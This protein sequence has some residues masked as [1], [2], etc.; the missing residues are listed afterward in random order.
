MIISALLLLATATALGYLKFRTPE[1]GLR[2]TVFRN[3]TFTG[4]P[5]AA[6]ADRKLSV[7]EVATA[8]GLPAAAPFGI[9]W[10][11]WVLIEQ[12]GSYE[13]RLTVDDG[14]VAWIG[15]RTIADVMG[16]PGVYERRGT[17]ML[18]RGLHPVQIRYVQF[19]G[20]IAVQVPMV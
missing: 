6:S 19:L 17:V 15:D 1:P 2:A 7:D 5:I 3:T 20:D 13:Y 14:A 16:P 10:S 18:E 12:P 4:I 11:G 8:A 9:D